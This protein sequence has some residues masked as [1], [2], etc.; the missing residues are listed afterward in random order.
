M[1]V[2]PYH[3]PG[4]AVTGRAAS[5]V[6]GGT[7]VAIVGDVAGDETG[8][9]LG[10]GPQG[11]PNVAY[12]AGARAVGVAARDADAGGAVM[13]YRS[14]HI[15][16][17]IAGAAFAAGTQVEGD[18]AGRAVPVGTTAGGVASGQALSAAAAA[19]DVVMVAIY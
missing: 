3:A 7:F 13:L 17:V 16:P 15:T 5:A 1:D 2:I 9:L 10:D 14:G 11:H 6:T 4:E 8:A 19:G 18:A 12:S